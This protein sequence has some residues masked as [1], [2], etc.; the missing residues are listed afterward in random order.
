MFTANQLVAHA[1]GD[2][3]MQSDWMAGNKTWK[4]SAA[5]IHAATYTIPFLFIT[6]SLTALLI[7]FGSH[8]IVDRYSLARYLVYVKNGPWY[9]GLHWDEKGKYQGYHWALKELTV[10]GYPP[11]RPIWL[12]FW[13]TVIA[14]NIIHV[15]C[16]ALAIYFF[17]DYDILA[18]WLVEALFSAFIII[19]V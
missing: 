11:H 7:I 15:F 12:A 5:A 13:L 1:V 17:H 14:D 19:G 18:L 6:Q 3:I 10:T 8:Y 16:N 9:R 4:N 2:Y